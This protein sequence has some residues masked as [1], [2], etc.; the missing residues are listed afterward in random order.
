MTA[1]AI[2]MC[3]SLVA[4]A[5]DTEG[6]FAVKGAGKR[7]CS[8]F[9][10]ASE[11]KTTDYYLYGGWLEGYLSHFNSTQENT[12]DVT[13]WQST[14]LMLALLQ[15]HCQTNSDMHFLT[16]TNSLIKTLFPIRLEANSI[17]T[18][19]DV[20]NTQSYYY[21]EILLRAKKRL[22]ALG[23][24]NGDV[25]ANYDNNDVKAFAAFQK[26]IGIRETGIPDQP[27]LM[28]LFLKPTEK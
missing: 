24:L 4:N 11:A 5:A 12:Y 9:L 3:G 18:K 2:G 16:A 23:F 10:K 6:K 8:D 15:R 14:E 1:C 20:Q 13:P 28:A 26:S 21:S 22:K 19:I 17:M 27:T 7:M 25:D